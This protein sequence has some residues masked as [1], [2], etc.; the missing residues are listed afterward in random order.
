MEG[1]PGPSARVQ[2]IEEGKHFGQRHICAEREEF[3]GGLPSKLAP[4]TYFRIVVLVAKDL[5]GR[6]RRANIA[7]A[8][9]HRLQ[10]HST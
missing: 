7:S 2:V 1:T 6:Q 3:W 8:D 10:R 9:T 4:G 5:T